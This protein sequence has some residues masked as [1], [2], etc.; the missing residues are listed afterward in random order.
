MVCCIVELFNSVKLDKL[1][2]KSYPPADW[3][4]IRY[5][6]GSESAAPVYQACTTTWSRSILTK[7]IDKKDANRLLLDI[8][9]AQEEEPTNQPIPLQIH[10][11]ETTQALSGFQS[12]Q[13][14]LSLVTSKAFPVTFEPKQLP[15]YF[16]RRV[17]L[18]L[19]QLSERGFHLRFSFSGNCVF[20]A[21]VRLYYKRCPGFVHDLV[22]F[23]GASAASGPQPGVCVEGAVKEGPCERPCQ[24]DGVWGPLEGEC[25]CPP[26]HQRVEATCQACVAGYHK[27]TNESGGCR[28]CPPNSSTTRAGAVECVCD[29]GYFRL[30]SDPYNMGCTRSPSAPVNVTV[31][32]LKNSTLSLRW[33]PPHD[34]GGRQEMKYDVHCQEKEGDTVGLWKKCVDLF[35]SASTGLTTT[36]V[37]L[38]GVNPN[39]D[40]QLSVR[41]W[42]EVSVHQPSEAN[43]ASVVIHRL[44]VTDDHR[45]LEHQQE[46]FSTWGIVGGLLGSL[47]LLA[48]VLTAVCTRRRKNIQLR[49]DPVF[50]S[51][52]PGVTYRR[53]EDVH[54]DLP[55]PTT[56]APEAV[57][58]LESVSDRLLTSLKDS[59]VHRNK[60][61]LGKELGKGEFGTV[62]EGLFSPVEGINIKVAVKT[63]KVGIYNQDD[64]EEF[65]KEAEIMKHFDHENVVKLLGVT[66]EREQDSP[67]PVPLVILPFMKHG[68]L[69]RFLVA[70][71]YGDIPMFVPYQSLLRFMIDIAAGMEYLSSHGFLHRD[72][73]ARNC[74]LGDDLHVCV[75]DFGLS[76]NIYSNNY[77]RQKVSVRMPVKWM[78]IE[79]LSESIYTSKSDVWSFGVTMWE[80]VSR[81]RTPYP[82]IHNHELLEHLE[83]EHRLKQPDCDAQLYEVMQSCWQRDVTLRPGFRELGERLKVHL[84]ALPVLEACQEAHY[85]NQGLEAA[86]QGGAQGDSLEGAAR[87]NV[88]L[89]T[90]TPAK[91]LLNEEEKKKNTEEEE[92]DGYLLQ[93]GQAVKKGE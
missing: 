60:L 72:L 1:G 23:E 70:T 14:V 73:A 35:L 90:P 49:E 52:H 66:L 78:A 31:Q 17:G 54:L 5:Q 61:T 41:A 43:L 81:G 91:V 22:R 51:L 87:G 89:P 42:N 27:P 83:G 9:F 80:I 32:R 56:T 36:E 15:E 68:D 2:W 26:G 53:D 47:L 18:D 50:L 93:T 84:C 85:I 59:A 64:L 24:E 92:E 13:N 28:L 8:T 55:E 19:G 7:W 4:E 34:T 12:G 71:R 79:S 16:D 44:K 57:Q 33:G 20:I 10:M 39:Y 40:Y 76:K 21:S 37:N 82:G 69:R 74:M 65:L 62:Y 77:Y 3:S 11:L 46:D 67:L 75:A 29:R 25:I 45:S 58:F 88:Y 86:C 6:V 63:M 38:T 48:L 30:P